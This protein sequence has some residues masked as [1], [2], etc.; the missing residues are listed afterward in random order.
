MN[1]KAHFLIAIIT[2]P[3]SGGT[4]AGS[5]SPTDEMRTIPGTLK[6]SIPEILSQA[7]ILG[8]GT[9]TDHYIQPDAN[10]SVEQ[11]N[12]PST[13]PGRAKNDLRH[14]PKPNC[15]DEYR[16]FISHPSNYGLR[17][18]YVHFRVILGTLL[19][20]DIRNTYSFFQAPTNFFD[21]IIKH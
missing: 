16:F 6:G 19:G 8:D 21:T 14:I 5:D 4:A 10:T 9:D 1:T 3:N 20:T 12:P 15:N 11:S 2:L 13:N 7:D 17:I 18:L